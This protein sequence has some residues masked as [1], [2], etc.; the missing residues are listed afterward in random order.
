MTLS[1]PTRP[2]GIASTAAGATILGLGGAAAAAPD[3]AADWW[4]ATAGV[5]AVLVVVAILGLRSAFAGVAVARPALVVA[6]ASLL[7]FALAHFYA[8]LDV[9]RA[10]LLF[11]VFMGA[12]AVAMI[13][14]GI[15]LARTAP[16]AGAA[17]FV[18]VLCGI[19]PIVT[20][21]VGGA[22]G[23]VPHFLAIAGWGCCW[24]A[25]GV[26]LLR[27]APDRARLA[28]GPMTAL[29]PNATSKQR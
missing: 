17:R 22:L 16:W 25:L 8:L 4:F 12:G 28:A 24:I 18:P 1:V 11:S 21:P 20:I 19:W 26:V 10:V 5:A 23:D 2:A 6:A 15:A 14:A 3:L 29:D 13:V 27:T 9:D 7:M